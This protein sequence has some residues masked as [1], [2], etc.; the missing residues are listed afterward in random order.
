[1]LLYI[2]VILSLNYKAQQLKHDGAQL[3]FDKWNIWE[4]RTDNKEQL[5]YI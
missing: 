2:V 3:Q 4:N 1:M 5:P